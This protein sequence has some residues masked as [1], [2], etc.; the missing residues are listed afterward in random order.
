MKIIK[1][2]EKK[3]KEYIKT[4]SGCKTKFSYKN[5]DIETD[6]DGSYVICPVCKAFI[7]I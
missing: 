1:K 5:R 6:R 3:E 4:C 7:A 2:G